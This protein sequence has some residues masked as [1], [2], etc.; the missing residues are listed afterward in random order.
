MFMGGNPPCDAEDNLR[1]EHIVIKD[2]FRGYRGSPGLG[3]PR[4]SRLCDMGREDTRQKTF[5]RVRVGLS[6]A[7]MARLVSRYVISFLY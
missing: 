2:W 6:Y 1:A 7:W 3:G 5:P 4:V